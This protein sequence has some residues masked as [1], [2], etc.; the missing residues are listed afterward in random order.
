VLLD[1]QGHN[2]GRTVGQVLLERGIINSHDGVMGKMSSRILNGSGAG[3]AVERKSGEPEV[4]ECRQMLRAFKS[5]RLRGKHLHRVVVKAHVQQHITDGIISIGSELALNSI[6]QPELLRNG[7]Y[8]NSCMLQ[9]HN[10]PEVA[11]KQRLG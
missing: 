11:G 3:L 10:W 7:E 8:V 1:F 9:W 2:S 4:G 6:M 5:R